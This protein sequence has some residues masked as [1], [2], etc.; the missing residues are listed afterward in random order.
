[1]KSSARCL[2][3]LTAFSLVAGVW[4]FVPVSCNA[5]DIL[6]K[7]KDELL[8]GFE[9][10]PQVLNKYPAKQNG[11][12][13]NVFKL[14]ALAIPTVDVDAD[15]G[16]AALKVKAPFVNVRLDGAKRRISVKV[17]FV[18]VDTSTKNGINVKA[19]Y[20][21][22]HTSAKNGLSLKAPLIKFNPLTDSELGLT[23]SDVSTDAPSAV[24]S[25]VPSALPAS[26]P[27]PVQSALPAPVQ[28]PV[29]Y[30]MLGAEAVAPSWNEQ[31]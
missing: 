28:S 26:Q 24:Q 27:S 12:R 20:V 19:P 16:E 22:V 17:P 13:L 25:P 8:N 21:R 6:S 5:Q 30:D 3:S 31:P 14:L 10:D 23:D 2:H 9:V 11:T 29:P 18:N 1:M 15:N 4:L 7:D